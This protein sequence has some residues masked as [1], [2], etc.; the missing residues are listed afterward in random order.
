MKTSYIIVQYMLVIAIHF[1]PVDECDKSVYM[2]YKE[3]F[4]AVL[5]VLSGF[6]FWKL[7]VLTAEYICIIQP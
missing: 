7:A 6:I 2:V 3:Y 4:L 1:H 5:S